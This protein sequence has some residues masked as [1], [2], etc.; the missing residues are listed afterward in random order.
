MDK[1]LFTAHDR[2]C[3]GAGRAAAVAAGL[4]IALW[5]A[6]VA[7]AADWAV[8]LVYHRFG[9]D[10]YPGTNIRIDQFE[11]HLQEI[12][13]G[14]YTVLAL[15]EI[16]RRLGAGEALPEN[17]LG[18]TINDAYLSVYREAWPRLEAAGLP[19]TLFVATDRVT[20]GTAGFMSWD[21]IRELHEAGVTIAN[22]T[23][24]H[25]HMV[26]ADLTEIPRDVQRAQARFEAELGIQ[27]TLFGYPYGEFSRA[28]RDQVATAGFD[29]AFAQTSGVAHAGQD[30]YALPRFTMTETFGG[31]ERFRMVGN[32]LPL[33][34]SE[35]VPSDTV[36][37]K[38]PPALGFTL[39][40]G[41]D[42]I[43]RLACFVQGQGRARIERL[44][45]RR[46]EIRLSRPLAPGRNRI[47]CTMP[48]PDG[49]W[50]WYGALFV[51]PDG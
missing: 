31:V 18:I 50:R 24:S 48:G 16:V 1:P 5:A 47:N 44:G 3:A 2:R 10:R 12:E 49:R 6:A 29:A 21:Q 9:E 42:D 32:A 28:V 37:T 51:V 36:I 43:R 25:P 40:P 8:I 13:A 34:V 46:V 26:A 20:Q 15:P 41:A 38:N 4:I 14:G 23:A 19:F 11:A 22:Q 7:A 39:D 35:V 33:P 30:F 27:P 17:T 45:V